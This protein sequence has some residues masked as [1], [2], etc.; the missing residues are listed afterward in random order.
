MSN[1]HEAQVL[2]LDVDESYSKEERLA[3][4]E[5]IVDEIVDRTLKQKDAN[6]ERFTALDS[7][8]SK[9]YKKFKRRAIG[10][11]KAD[12]RFTGEMLGALKVIKSKSTKGKVVVGYKAN[13][14]QNSKAKGHITGDVGQKRD[15]LGDKESKNNKRIL[16][17]VTDQFPVEN[18]EERRKRLLEL[19]ELRRRLSGED[20]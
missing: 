12:L 17:R 8:K 4:G 1:K 13:T 2:E 19:L 10:S 6:G 14:T 7:G 9:G 3:I 20:S 5:E 11:A 18:R 16:E 15:F